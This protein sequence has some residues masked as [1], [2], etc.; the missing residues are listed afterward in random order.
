MLANRTNIDTIF[1]YAVFFPLVD[2]IGQSACPDHLVRRLS[3][4][5][6]PAESRHAGRVIQYSGF[7]FQP[8]RDSRTSTTSCTSAVVASYRIFKALDFADP[9]HDAGQRSRQDAA[10]GASNF[11]RLVAYNKR[12]VLKDV[13]FTVAPGNPSRSSAHRFR[14]DYA[15]QLLMR[16]TT[17]RRADSAGRVM[18]RLTAVAARELRRGLAGDFLFTA[19]LPATSVG[20]EDI[21]DERVRWAPRKC[22]PIVSFS[23]CRTFTNRKCASA[24]GYLLDKNN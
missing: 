6:K 21:S 11:R 14:Q 7:L 22:A 9:D 19:R 5:A 17:C 3:R 8:I 15:Y 18:S 10:E 16:F 13:S 2:F 12:M 4:D 23:A 1:Y 20:R 24:A